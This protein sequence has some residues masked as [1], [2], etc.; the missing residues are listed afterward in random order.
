MS[1]VLLEELQHQGVADADEFA[2]FGGG[3]A[4]VGGQTIKMIEAIGGRS[5]RQGSAAHV[6][7]L[8]LEAD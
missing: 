7:V 3:D 8:F 1:L 6:G 4:G 2:L 5:G